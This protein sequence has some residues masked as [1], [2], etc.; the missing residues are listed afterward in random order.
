MRAMA[1]GL[2]LTALVQSSSVTISLV[3]PLAGAGILTAAHVYPYA[4]G[5]NVGTTVTALLAALAGGQPA[6][7]AI[8]FAHMLFNVLGIG[9]WYPLRRVPLWLASRFA[10]LAVRSRVVPVVYVVTVY[11]LIPLVLIAIMR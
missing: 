3:V 10:S 6:G 7:L 9:V 1:L 11:L 4:L 8:A 2:V 5:A